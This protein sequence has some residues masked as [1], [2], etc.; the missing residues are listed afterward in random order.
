VSR[1]AREEGLDGDR[2]SEISGVL[3]MSGVDVCSPSV[4]DADD[5][6]YEDCW[7][8]LCIV[9]FWPT[10]DDVVSNCC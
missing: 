9:V 1:S 10:Q 2:L 8:L 5:A 6:E 7:S 4:D 3:D